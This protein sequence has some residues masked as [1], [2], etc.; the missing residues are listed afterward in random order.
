MPGMDGVEFTRQVAER[1]LASA[2]VI[3][4]ALDRRVLD[5]VKTVSEG[6][7]LQVL[8]AVEKPLTARILSE[9]LSSYRPPLRPGPQDGAALTAGEIARL[10]AVFQPIVDL[11]TGRIGAAEALPGGGQPAPAVVAAP[12]HAAAFTDR[13]IDLICAAREELGPTLDVVLRLPD[14]PVSDA[15]LSERLAAAVQRRGAEPGRIVL[16]IGE[17]LARPDSGSALDVVARLRVKGFGLWLDD[18]R[19]ASGS[20]ERLARVPLTGLRLAADLVAGA[21][22]EGAALEEALGLART[23]GI[24]AVAN[25]VDGPESFESLLALGCGHAQGS[26]IAAAMPAAELAGWAGRWSPP[27]ALRGESP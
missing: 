14:V 19:P 6:Y 16:A 20:V 18:Y 24:P 13:M 27:P 7:G 17:R 12:D 4:S 8:G 11:A 5:A 3:A 26:F 10:A 23:L 9:L 15:T 21:A 2:V 22:G 1:G 25:G